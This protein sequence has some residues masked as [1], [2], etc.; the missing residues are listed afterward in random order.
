M[1]TIEPAPSTR[2]GLARSGVVIAG[3]FWGMDGLYGRWLVAPAYQLRIGR[4]SV[5]RPVERERRGVQ[6][7]QLC[8]TSAEVLNPGNP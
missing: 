1:A 3:M 2:T 7:L 5:V 4:W 6:P 8:F